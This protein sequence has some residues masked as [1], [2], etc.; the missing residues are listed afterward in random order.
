MPIL[1]LQYDPNVGPLVPGVIAL[2]DTLRDVSRG[3]TGGMPFALANFLIDT[4]ADMT[5]VSKSLAER[6]GL[7]IVS[8][9]DMVTPHGVA[10]ANMYLCDVG[11][12]FGAPNPAS[13][14][15]EQGT[16]HGFPNFQVLEYGGRTD[17]YEGLLGRDIICRGFF[18][19]GW[20]SRF[21]L[22]F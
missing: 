20:D 8:Q 9:V 2:P 17:R 6:V 15:V 5:C 11:V 16:I 1:S 3:I 7:E 19:I 22:G 14:V 10:P 4:G 21:L 12:V 18:Q 13:G